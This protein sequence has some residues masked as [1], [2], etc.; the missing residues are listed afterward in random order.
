[1]VLMSRMLLS[2]GAVHVLTMI[3]SLIRA[4]VLSVLLGPSEYGIFGTVEQTVL[5]VVQLAALSLPFTAMKYMSEGHSEGHEQFE[6][7]FVAFLRALMVLSLFAMIAV[8]LL[9]YWRPGIFGADLEPYRHLFQL[10]LLGVPAAMLQIHFVNTFAAAQRGAASAWLNFSVG[11][12]LAAAAIGGYVWLGLPGLFG[13]VVLGGVVTAVVVLRYLTRALSLRVLRRSASALAE[14]RRNPQIVS[15]SLFLYAAMSAYSLTM[16]ATRYHVFGQLGSTAAGLLQAHLGV[17]LAVGSIITPLNGLFFT[18]LVNRRMPV[19]DKMLAANTF[20]GT[21]IVVLLLTGLGVA[22]FPELTL[23]VLF[24]SRFTVGASVLTWF[25][26]WQ[27][28]YQITN[29]YLQLLIG[30]NDVRFFALVTCAGYGV[31]AMLF[32]PMIARFGLGGAA[33]ALSA[34]MVISAVAAAVRLRRRFGAGI[35]PHIAL[36]ATMLLVALAGAGSLFTP[37]T[38]LTVAGFSLRAAYAATTGVVYWF[39]L[40]PAER[41]AIVSVVRRRPPAPA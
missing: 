29:I 39:A 33:I 12:A 14:L 8:P 37:S 38:E 34:A 40:S 11:V 36:R 30:L 27:C 41:S 20:A 32:G 6:R 25:I 28:L 31:A 5:S 26:I 24:S 2:I 13:G 3:V 23:T 15:V 22:L 17:A 4:K 35:A 18:P 21:V 1:M 9:L 16:L 10:A 7:T 19:S